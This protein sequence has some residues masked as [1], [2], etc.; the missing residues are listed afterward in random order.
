MKNLK[1]WVSITLLAAMLLTV[2]TASAAVYQIG[3]KGSMVTEIQKRLTNLGY[4]TEYVDGV[5]DFG[6]Y[7]AVWSYQK[8]HNLKVDGIAG[9]QTLGAMG[10]IATSGT[11]TVSAKG[12]DYG[13]SGSSVVALQNA[14]TAAGYPVSVDGKYGYQ[15]YVAVWSYQQK[16]GLP[17]TGTADAKTLASLGVI[18]VVGSVKTSNIKYGKTNSS[19]RMVQEALAAKGFYKSNIDGR[20]GWNTYVALWSFQQ[21]NGLAVTGEA[22]A[23]TLAKLGINAAYTGGT[24]DYG[25]KGE[26][27]RNLQSQLA[28]KG[29][30]KAK[31]DGVYGFSTY[32]AVW[33][34]QRDHGLTVDGVAGPATQALI[35]K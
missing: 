11:G 16:K 13:A 7:S 17:V 15:T 2:F 23:A 20:F 27:V 30:F 31:I 4:Y 18:A 9:N 21:A 14:L 33:T 25:A 28:S 6:V 12:L 5:Y 29:Y 34:F 3:S 24:L 32:E 10:L 35:F 1:K 26:A 19:V 22:D 8:D